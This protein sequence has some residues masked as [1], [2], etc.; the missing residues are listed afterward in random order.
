MLPLDVNHIFTYLVLPD[1]GKVK[2]Q[3]TQHSQYDGEL[4]VWTYWYTYQAQAIIDPYGL[5][6]TLAYNGDGSLN[7]I[8][9]P[10]GRWIQIVYV[11]TPWTN[12]F[13][14][15]DRVIDHIAASDGRSVQY[16]YGYQAWSPG[17][18]IYTYLGNVVY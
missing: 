16:N 13:G 10:A 14:Q 3:A 15:H 5:S 6:T 8:T 18:M 12:G 4:H 17:T 2:F 7:T 1:G 9:E 11:T